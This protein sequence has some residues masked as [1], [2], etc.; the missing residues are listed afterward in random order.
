MRHG[1]IFV[2][3]VT[4][5]Q[6]H[7][8]AGGRLPFIF[9]A[10]NSTHSPQGVCLSERLRPARL[11]GS[12]D[13]SVAFSCDGARVYCSGNVGRFGRSDNLFNLGWRQTCDA[14]DRIC[15]AQSVFCFGS[16]LRGR[17]SGDREE[18]QSGARVRRLDLTANFATGSVAQA[19]AVIRWLAGRSVARAKRGRAGDESV[20]F[21]NSR[22]MLKAYVKGA[23][24]VAHGADKNSRAVQWCND[25]GIVRIEVELKR[26]LLTE[27]GLDDYEAIT[28]EK[29]VSAYDQ[30]TD[31]FRTVDRSDEPDIL[32][33]IPARS[34]AYAAAWLAG[35]DLHTFCSRATLFRHAKVCREYG[36]EL[37]EPRNIEQFPTR[38]RIVDLTPVEVPDW[39]QLENF[40]VS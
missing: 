27:M 17:L 20:W 22:K 3:W 36:L 26:R 25:L 8:G 7:S 10:L 6:Y 9:A 4:V 18:E 15:L 39:Y 40:K 12:F 38:V 31:I 29:L 23:E 35:Q 33:S 14:L 32:S 1:S 28:D 21:S 30:A 5:T 34:R 37:M 24:L 16:D 19:H 13:T 11:S 2:D